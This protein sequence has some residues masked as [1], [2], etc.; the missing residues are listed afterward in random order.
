[1]SGTNTLPDLNEAL[2][3]ARVVELGGFTAAS[4][5]LRMP[6]ATVSRKVRDL[7]TRLGTRLLNRTTRRVSLTEAGSAYFELASA[8]L[9]GLEDAESAVTRLQD[10]PRGWLRVTAPLLGA[11]YLA[12]PI[13]EFQLR[14]PEVRVAIELKNEVV[15]IV[16]QGIDLAIRAAPL[17]DS[18]FAVRPLAQV[19][20]RLVASPAYLAG[21]A[22]PQRV[23]DLAE[24]RLLALA[25]RA[26]VGKL[27]WKLT[28][29]GTRGVREESL[30]FLP[31]FVAN[32]PAPLHA[33]AVAGLGIALVP[34]PYLAA[35]LQWGRLVSV[36][37]DW[38]GGR[39]P[40]S[41]VFASRRGMAPKVR[42]F[43]D[44]LVETFAGL[45]RE[46]EGGH[47]RRRA[48]QGAAPKRRAARRSVRA[49]T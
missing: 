28:T 42:V 3:L 40:L 41:A 1:M 49:L 16:A 31:T 14:Y 21:R 24:H 22:V 46:L 25:A 17:G 13:A 43:V 5:A 2:V 33:A 9:R 15:D 18:S 38:E 29:S 12:G 47:D 7:E 6:K 44:F 32:D 26:A 30:T 11:T 20:Q 4:V 23:A 19:R 39:V 36:L 10:A 37:P 8:A 45:Q 34:E 35:D 27:T 48:A